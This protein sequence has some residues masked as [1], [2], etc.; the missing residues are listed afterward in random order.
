MSYSKVKAKHLPFFLV[1]VLLAGCIIKPGPSEPSLEDK[2]GQMLMVG[3]RGT[4]I[5]RNDSILR[6][7]RRYNLGGVVLFDRDLLQKRGERNISSP[8]QLKVLTI[9]LQQ[10]ATTPLLIAVDQEG[11]KVARLK[12]EAGFPAT[13]SHRDLGWRDDLPTTAKEADKIAATLADVG[14]NLNLAPVVDLCVNAANPVIAGLD[15]CFSDNPEKVTRHALAYIGAH[16]N[17]GVLTTLKHFP[18]H[19][20]SRTDTHLGFTDISETWSANELL[21][22]T[23]IIAAGQA[24]A[25][26]TAHVFNARLDSRYPATLSRTVVTD[27]LRNRFCFDGV[28]ISDDLQMK[29]I[30]DH[31]GFE[32][33]IFQAIHAGVDILLFGN[34]LSH[35]EEI[36]PRAV[37]LIR[38][39]VRKG[40][41]TEERINQSYH[42]I[43]SLKDRLPGAS[44]KPPA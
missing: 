13:L 18:G 12:E 32:A 15:R 2:I 43:M 10:E 41:I 11:G 36:V 20:S 3:F 7:I 26:M 6:D 35:D 5:T 34:N 30:A 44:T 24:D 38:K 9:S 31:F 27:L 25:I 42:R 29:A 14:I 21:P 1:L 40:K 39:M 8:A 16:H 17:H 33:A 22:F 37:A 19:G 28:I 4:N 23:R